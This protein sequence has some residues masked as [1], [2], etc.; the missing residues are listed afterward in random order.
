MAFLMTSLAWEY[1]VHPWSILNCIDTVQKPL[2]QDRNGYQ[3]FLLFVAHEVAL[4]C[5]GKDVDV[6]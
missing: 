3:V 1:G 5:Q 6:R 2:S 4:F